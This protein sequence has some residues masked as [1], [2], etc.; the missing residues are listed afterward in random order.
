MAFSQIVKTHIQ[1]SIKLIKLTQ[2]DNSADSKT[3]SETKQNKN[4]PD[5]SQSIGANEPFVKLAGR[6]VTNV[7][8]LTINETGFIPTLKIIFIDQTGEFSGSYFPKRNLMISVYIASSS[9]KLKPVRSDYLITDIKTMAANK[10]GPTPNLASGITYIISAELFVP[11]L[12]NNVSKS[13]AS[14]TS[15]DTLK[16]VCSSLGLG[17][18]QNEFTPN[19]KMTW[20]NINTSPSNFIREIVAHSYQDEDTFFTS[21]INKEYIFNFINIHEQLK[22]LDVDK[23]FKAAAD[24]LMVNIDQSQKNNSATQQLQE[25]TQD[26][27]LTNSPEANGKSNFIYEANLISAHGAILKKDGYKKKIFYYDH[28]ESNEQKKFKEF[29]TAPL[30]TPG[31]SEAAMLI[32]DDEGLSEIGN[33]KWMN[34]NYGNTH[35][36][37]NAARVFNTHNLVEIEKIK[38]RVLLKGINNQVIRGS[39][40]PVVLTQKFTDKLKKET[41]PDNPQDID[42]TQNKMDDIAMDSELSGRYWVKEAIYHYDIN[43]PLLFSTE[44]ILARREWVPSKITFTANA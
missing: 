35:E 41:D 34:I 16:Q 39:V 38:L 25:E 36:H 5:A 42:V 20:I 28:F 31:L 8:H 43:D 17:Y 3:P 44:L 18:G 30:N 22:A 15:V 14:S 12:Y 11:R 2:A 10:N 32:P 27:Y 9:D 1:P 19:D 4:M 23:M 26:N 6:I 37:W 40:V 29:F 24:P 7:E 13:Y 33:K 21:F